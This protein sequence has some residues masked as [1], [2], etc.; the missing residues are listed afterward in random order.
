MSQRTAYLTLVLSGLLAAC[1]STQPF[2]PTTG[3]STT[4]AGS[5]TTGGTAVSVSTVATFY[6]NGGCPQPPTVVAIDPSG[7]VY[8]VNGSLNVIQADGG[9]SNLLPLVGDVLAVA[10]SSA[11]VFISEG[12]PISLFSVS[13]FTQKFLTGG[14]TGCDDSTPG[15]DGGVG[16]GWGRALAADASDNVYVA[17]WNG[18]G[19]TRIRKVL[20]NGTTQPLSGTGDT[21][22][23]DGPGASA[24]FHEPSGIAV[25]INK[26]VYVSDSA[27]NR[28]RLI[29]S[30]GTTTTLAGNGDAGFDDNDGPPNTPS[31]ATFNFPTGIAVDAV[32]NLY[33]A[34]TNNNAIRMI[35]PDGGTTT[36][37]GNGTKGNFN[38]TL[39]RDGTSEFSYPLSVA[40]D[41][42]G[43]VY[44]AD[45][46]NCAIRMIKPAP[47]K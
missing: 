9:V 46:G 22:Y 29:T 20:F 28:I 11:G 1:S 4:G 16:F 18:L 14:S 5:T 31:S 19:C 24:V 12:D 27:N 26:N 10:V 45:Q 43:D 32:G 41:R 44:V 37:A 39:G 40:V 34:D 6:Q 15:V 3:G 38:G 33:V 25:D 47:A 35:S 36:L 42:K 23:A 21:G 13:S 30:D 7:V 2:N 8:A 17:D